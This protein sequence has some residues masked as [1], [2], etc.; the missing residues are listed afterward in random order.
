MGIGGQ[1]YRTQ[2]RAGQ[3]VR[4]WLINSSSFLAY[5]ISINNHTL[6][7]VELDG[8]EVTPIPEQRCVYLNVGQRASV[9][10]A[11]D[12][13]PGSYRIRATLP[14]SCFLPY[15]PYTSAGLESVSYEGHGFSTYAGVD[16]DAEPRGDPGNVTN[17]YGVENN[18]A[19]SDVWEGCDDMPF[20]VPK[21][22]RRMGAV[23]IADGN[24][25]YIEYVSAGAECESDF[26]QQGIHVLPTVTGQPEYEPDR[27]C[28]K[29]TLTT[30][31]RRRTLPLRT[32]QRSGNY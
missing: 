24:H 28:Y 14:C 1:L 17:P 13:A 26:H 4:L 12:Q 29:S 32:A 11:A 27:P 15:A 8:V 2:V 25:H 21:P 18:G 9:V 20:D 6:T 7:T 10:L 3:R 19:R 23:E 5:W 16:P 30:P 22:M 31:N